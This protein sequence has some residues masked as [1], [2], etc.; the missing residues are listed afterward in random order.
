M[1]VQNNVVSKQDNKAQNNLA[2]ILF[3]QLVKK[4]QSASRPVTKHTN[5]RL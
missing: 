5:N 3:W 1:L 4:T 2:L